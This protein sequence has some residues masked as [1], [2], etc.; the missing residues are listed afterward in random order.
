MLRNILTVFALEAESQG[1][2]DNVLYCGVG[3]I[4]AAYRLTRYLMSC[5]PEVSPHLIVNLGS[6]GSA[7]FPLGTVVNCTQFIQR[8]FNATA[9][10]YESYVTPFEDTGATLHNGLR[11]SSYP[12]GICGCGDNFDTTHGTAVWNV[13]DME[14]YALAKIC[15][16]ED[17]PFACFKYI[18][19]SAD[20]EAADSWSTR[21]AEAAAKL[22][23]AAP[24]L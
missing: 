3:K 22:K 13:V 24:C 7:Y 16:L 5:K 1:Q 10:G 2:F 9:L 11:Y 18:T 23:E 6:A 17:I 14:S 12:E 20:A 15:L 21:L 4:N 8:D 19:D